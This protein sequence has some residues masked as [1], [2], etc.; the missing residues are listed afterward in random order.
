M[1]RKVTYRIQNANGTWETQSREAYDRGNGALY[2]LA[3]D[4]AAD[5]SI[6]PAYLVYGNASGM[7]IETC[8]G[9]LD[10]D[11]PEECTR[12]ERNALRDC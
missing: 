4:G 8:A 6:S 1:L 9:F 11:N 7:L 10:D 5:A 2:D 12:R 3:Q